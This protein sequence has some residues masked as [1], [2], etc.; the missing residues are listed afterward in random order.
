METLNAEQNGG[1]NQVFLLPMAVAEGSPV[2]PAYPSGLAV[3]LGAYITVLKVRG[4]IYV[5]SLKQMCLTR[6]DAIYLF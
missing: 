4:D 1:T 2:H 6:I 5:A 3:N